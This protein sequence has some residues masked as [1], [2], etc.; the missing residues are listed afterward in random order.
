[1][2]NTAFRTKEKFTIGTTDQTIVM[3]VTVR[4]QGEASYL[5]QYQVEIPPGFEYSG[6]ENYETKVCG[7]VVSTQLELVV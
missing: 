5:T 4:N 7:H 6:V 1:M 2:Q 3:N